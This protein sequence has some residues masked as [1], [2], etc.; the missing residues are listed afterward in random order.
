MRFRSLVAYAGVLIATT[1][2]VSPVHAQSQAT[3]PADPGTPV[4]VPGGVTPVPPPG[5][6]DAAAPKAASGPDPVVAKV[7]QQE[8]HMSDMSEAAQML[9]DNMRQMPPNVL[10][11]M[12][13]DQLI[14]RDALVVAA[15]KQGLE[16]DPQVKRDM[17][18]AM[19]TA[20][21]NALIKRDVGPTIT[22]QAIHA[23]YD[24]T[25][26]GKP[27]ET[28]V[29]ARHILLNSKAEA[30]KVIAELNAGA[31]FATLAKKY[32][33]DPAGAQG[34]DLGFFKKDEML[35]EF[36]D[37]AFALKPGEYTKTP[38]QTRYGWHVIQAVSRRQAAQPTYEEARDQLRQ[39]MIEEGLQKVIGAA[40]SEVTIV[41]FNPDGSA[42]RALDLAEPPP[43]KN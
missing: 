8:I 15:R 2:I 34:G 26:A 30:E 21:Q 43:A 14:D 37:A 6:P 3:Q 18:R 5:A 36:S 24:A 42:Q 38:V 1:S 13:L 20:L 32:S 19:D 17:Q 41:R 25:I 35:P 10:Y 31:D 39:K 33:T 7:D 12:L 4:P 11:P 40:R 9:P 28:Q 27:G 16:N 23:R 29:D 22:E